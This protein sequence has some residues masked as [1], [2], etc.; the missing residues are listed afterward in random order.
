M[1]SGEQTTPP[2]A[3]LP[4]RSACGC[5]VDPAWLTALADQLDRL[6]EQPATAAEAAECYAAGIT[7]AQAAAQIAA[8]RDADAE[9]RA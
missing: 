8:C 1:A 2:P 7:A 3:S 5:P 4:Y 6:G 9:G